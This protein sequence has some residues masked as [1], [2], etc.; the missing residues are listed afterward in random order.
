LPV[1]E[2]SKRLKVFWKNIFLKIELVEAWEIGYYWVK[3]C[4]PDWHGIWQFLKFKFFWEFP[5]GGEGSFFLVKEK[6][7][8][9]FG[10]RRCIFFFQLEEL[11]RVTLSSR[12]YKLFYKLT[13]DKRSQEE[14][15]SF[16][17][18]LNSTTI[19]RN[20]WKE[21]ILLILE[22]YSIPSP[23]PD[24]VNFLILKKKTHIR[25]EVQM[26]KIVF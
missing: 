8:S 26:V 18:H 14:L 6:F 19:L 11:S 25:H 1:W 4:S 16:R 5:F 3:P 7:E 2:S 10:M 22:S 9:K 24:F 12:K 15:K 13:F 17:R 23:F 20:C 21:K